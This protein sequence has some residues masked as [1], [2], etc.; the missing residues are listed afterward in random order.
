MLK[1]C[2]TGGNFRKRFKLGS[3][4]LI[5]VMLIGVGGCNRGPTVSDQTRGL[6]QTQTS[7]PQY[8]PVNTTNPALEATMNVNRLLNNPEN[9]LTKEQKDKIRPILQEL[10]NASNLSRDALQ[11]SANAINTVF[12]DAQKSFLARPAAGINGT[13]GTAGTTGTTGNA[14]TSGV[15]GTAGPAGTGGTSGAG[16][17]NGIGSTGGLSDTQV[18]AQAI[19]RKVLDSLK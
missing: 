13:A 16:G 4:L 10:N 6:G 14:G 19:Y 5:T 18:N 17:T 7:Q 12:T 3:L 1:H 2:N 15:N 9:T 8:S 11:K